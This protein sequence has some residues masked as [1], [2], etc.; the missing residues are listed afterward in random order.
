VAELFAY[1]RG[2]MIK[3]ESD[4]GRVIA[5]HAGAMPGR[6]SV[7]EAL[8][9]PQISLTQVK[10]YLPQLEQFSAN[11]LEQLEIEAHYD[12]YLQRQQSDA[13]RLREEEALEIPTTLDFA[14]IRGLSHEVRQK[15]QHHQPPTLAAAGRI[16]GVTPAALQALWLH[17]RKAQATL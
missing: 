6:L 12:G 10:T 13:L 14:E 2:T 7:F 17:L 15:L 11:S 1:A 3:K 16:S 9:R 8:K 5:T 4:L